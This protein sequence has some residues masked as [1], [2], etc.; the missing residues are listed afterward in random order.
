M[1][2]YRWK[3]ISI[4]QYRKPCKALYCEKLIDTITD[5]FKIWSSKRCS[6]IQP[7]PLCQTPSLLGLLNF[8]K[9]IWRYTDLCNCDDDFC[10]E[11][12]VTDN[13][14]SIFFY[15]RKKLMLSKSIKSLAHETDRHLIRMKCQCNEPASGLCKFKSY[16]YFLNFLKISTWHFETVFTI[17]YLF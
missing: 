3:D 12:C 9:D 11:I 2:W 1:R 13:N 8:F 7:F 15:Q 17:Q 5:K 14:N 4:I 6:N 16:R 10:Q